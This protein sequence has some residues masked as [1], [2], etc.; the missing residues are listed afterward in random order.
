MSEN[1]IIEVFPKEIDMA[2]VEDQLE[3]FVKAILMVAQE[4]V[5]RQAKEA[6]RKKKSS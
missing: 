5:E 4:E 6:E 3:L 2:K 1:K